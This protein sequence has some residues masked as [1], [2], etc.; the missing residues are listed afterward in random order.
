GEKGVGTITLSLNAP[1]NEALMDIYG[2]DTNLHLDLWTATIIRHRSTTVS[3]FPKISD[4]FS[5]GK[6]NLNQAFQR[7][8]STFANA[9][10][11]LLKRLPNGHQI[12][13]PQFVESVRYD[14]NPLV[15]AEEGREVVK[16]LEIITDQIEKQSKE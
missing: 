15:T 8:A 5:L 16:K 10:K 9:T 6:D 3:T 12:L 14:M 2:T 1:R 13:I 7:I 11:I 4:S